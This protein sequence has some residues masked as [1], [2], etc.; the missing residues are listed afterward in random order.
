VTV[1]EDLFSHGA[2]EMRVLVRVFPDIAAEAKVA[3]TVL[4]DPALS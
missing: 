2:E 1:D 4:R 3:V